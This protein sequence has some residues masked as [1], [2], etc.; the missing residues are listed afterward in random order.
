M[1]GTGLCVALTFS[2]PLLLYKKH[3]EFEGN[4]TLLQHKH[5]SPHG[6][7]EEASTLNTLCPT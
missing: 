4:Q 3:E 1:G 2:D 5:F 6:P 7:P